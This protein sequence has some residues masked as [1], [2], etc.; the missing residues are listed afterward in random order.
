[1]KKILLKTRNLLF[2]IRDIFDYH[3]FSKITKKMPTHAILAITYYCNSRCKMCNIWKRRKAKEL[4]FNDW[5]KFFKDKI[6]RK[7]TSVSFTGGEVFLNPNF[8]EIVQSLLV[9][10]EQIN[11]ID[12]TSN[13]LRT[14]L[15]V[16]QVKKIANYCNIKGVRLEVNISLDGLSKEHDLIRGIKGA[17]EK[18]TKTLGELNKIKDQCNLS[19]SSGT[20]L[21]N[22]NIDNLPRFEKWA[23]K[24]KYRINYQLP[25]FHEVFVSNINLRKR[26]SFS[27]NQLMK[28]KKILKRLSKSK[29]WRDFTSYYWLDMYEMYFKNGKRK[30]PC[31]FQ[32]DAFAI[33]SLGDV[34]YCLSE[35]SIGNYKNKDSIFNIF[36]NKQN[37]LKKEGMLKNACLK[38]NS[39]CGV[40]NSIKNQFF[41]Y[42]NHSIK[43]LFNEV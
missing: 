14:K 30:T 3:V 29:N 33:D 2:W 7:V 38:C 43:R 19:L 32:K 27:K 1:M 13:G 42:F 34:Y 36:F 26:L 18:S 20:M 21:L 5:E 15:I 25:G 8:H 17:F 9:E 28:L 31:P 11:K 12:I 35:P 23:K 40:K 41:L 10:N 24:H 4:T 22:L 16:E 39:S 37:L 6:F